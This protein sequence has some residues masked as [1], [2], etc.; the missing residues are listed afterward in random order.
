ML[1]TTACLTRESPLLLRHPALAASRKK[2]L[3]SLAALVN[4]ARRASA[5]AIPEDVRDG[6]KSTMVN[7]AHNVWAGVESFLEVAG[8]YGVK[9]FEITP[10]TLSKSD[11]SQAIEHAETSAPPP[12][13]DPTPTTVSS[14]AS[15]ATLLSP[16]STRACVTVR[17]TQELSEILTFIDDQLLST[18]AAFIGHIHAHTRTAHSSSYAHLIDMTRETIAK[19]R[20]LLV[21]VEAVMNCSALV[22]EAATLAS[23]RDT[24]HV[25]TTA[26]VSAAR[27]ATSDLDGDASKVE[28]EERSKLLISATAV[29]RAG[30][31]CISGIQT[32][33]AARDANA[34]PFELVLSN[35]NQPTALATTE[36]EKYGP[37]ASSSA[38]TARTPT[39][40]VKDVGARFDHADEEEEERAGDQVTQLREGQHSPELSY[41]RYSAEMDARYEDR[42][43]MSTPSS[44]GVQHR[45]S[46]SIT[47]SGATVT[48]QRNGS[49]NGL[50][51]SHSRTSS[52]ASS[53]AENRVVS[54]PMARNESSRTSDSATSSRSALSNSTSATS[55]RSSMSVNASAHSPASSKYSER[56]TVSSRS[57]SQRSSPPLAR[58]SGSYRVTHA[59]PFPS[60]SSASTSSVN[61][62]YLERDYE[63]R[64][65]AF[66]GDGHV[67]GGTLECLVERM[68]LHDTTIDP[69][70]SNAFFLTFRMFTTPLELSTELYRRY[71]IT[72]PSDLSADEVKEW[73]KSKATPVRLRVY[74]LLKTWVESHWHHETDRV[75]IDSLLEFSREKLAVTMA[76]AGQRLV[77]LVQKRVMC[78]AAL[79]PLRR[80]IV[81]MK[82]S[83]R[84]RAGKIV[85]QADPYSPAT[86]TH[87][88]LPP[89]SIAPKSLLSHIRSSSNLLSSINIVD[90][91][92]L[93]LARQITIM[94]SRIYCLIKPEE[95]LCQEL[96]KKGAATINVRAMSTLSTRLTGWVAETIL[97]EQDAKKRTGLVKYFI[98]LCDVRPSFLE[99]RADECNSAAIR[100]TTTTPSWQSSAPSPR[101]PSRDS[102]R[103][104]K[105]SR[106]SISPTSTRFES[107]SSTLAITTSTA[108][109]CARWWTSRACRSWGST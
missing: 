7:M 11:S 73:T 57:V 5:P 102:R 41:S 32:C 40:D 49:I 108:L 80:G 37:M 6:E 104:G 62:W 65:I 8:R 60:S 74:N 39:R 16:T 13:S 87:G 58:R 48:T 67:T 53:R 72:P 76:S 66:N 31:N 12:Q 51:I 79:P 92:P 91:D 30:G 71:S 107:R 99:L 38:S 54:V 109:D 75:I 93:E 55:P 69:T 89:A 46:L 81:R 24:L 86:P 94:E 105:G 36:Y 1:S 27:I 50:P 100:S 19:V 20:E 101:Q 64:E 63:A 84:M 18:I 85:D 82:S 95:L 77:D 90:I 103:P 17:T 83:D 52:R 26:L 45:K 15:V 78:A 9:V 28:D 96:G 61:A 2:I 22:A 59:T 14:S 42:K 43:S 23:H 68:S 29:L 97:N 25:A 33:I 88:P 47:S 35:V 34:G 10:P 21:V 4:Q 56:P 3:S 98:K 70:F 44:A 106:P